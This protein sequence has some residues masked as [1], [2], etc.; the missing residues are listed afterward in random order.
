VPDDSFNTAR[1]RR[2]VLD[3]WAASPARFREDAN[4]E[5]DYALG[6]YRDRVVV[7]LAQ[8]AADAATRAGVPG[9]LALALRDGTLTAA[10][11]GAPLDADGVIALSTLRAS[12]KRGE[13]AVGR[14]GVGFAA[15][16]AV[17]DEPSISSAAGAVRWS[18]QA[19][20]DAVRQVPGLAGELAARSGHVPVLRLPFPSDQA[21]P[22]GYTTVVTLPLRDDATIELVTRLLAETGPALLLALPALAEITI[23]SVGVT[24]RLTAS[25][26]ATSA[27][28]DADAHTADTD[29]VTVT[30]TSDDEISR[31]RTAS[32]S[33]AL[34]QALLAGRPAEERA[35]PS[36]ALQWAFRTDTAGLGDSGAVLYAPTPTDEPLVLPALL[37]ASFPLSPDRR[38]VAPGPLTDYLVSRAASVYAA[39][40]PALPASPEILDLV[41]GPVA[42]GPLDGQVRRAILALLPETPFLPGAAGADQGDGGAEPAARLRP[43]D[44]VVLDVNLPELRDFLAPVLSGLIAG[45]SRHPAYT[46]LGVRRLSLAELCDMLAAL[47]RPSAWWRGLYG[48]LA[49]ADPVMR[50]ELGALPVPLADGRLVRGPRG[51]LLPG[52]GLEH[53]ERLAVLGLRAVH[54]DAAHPLLSRLGAV[55]A[56]PRSILADAATRAAVEASL[57]EEDPEP[58]A[59]AVLGLVAAAGINPDEL[60]WLASLALPG[61][62]GDWYPADEL[63]LPGGPLAEVIAQDTPFGTISEDFAQRHGAQTLETV[64]VLGSFGLVKEEDVDLGDPDLGV[65]GAT[66]W[67]EEIRE[68]LGDSDIPPLA[69]EVIAVR[70]LDLVDPD[71]WPRALEL[72]ARPPL[73]AALIEPTR[74]LLGDGRYAEAPSYTTWW[75]RRHLVIG[76]QRPAGLRAPDTDPL[77][78][79]LY[80]E[81]DPALAAALADA[82]IAR[83]LGVRT[84]LTEL[85]DEPG[86]AD[87][88]LGRLADQ[89]RPVARAQL[90]ALWAALGALSG[91]ASDATPPDRV[92]AVI[93]DQVVVA[94]AAD[95]LV[96][97]APDLWPLLAARPLVLAPYDL[98]LGLADLLD[99][100]L[101]SEE[102]PGVVE[103]PGERR[104]VPGAAAALLPDAPGEYVAHEKLLVDGVALPW[105]V[106]DGEV[107]AA[108]PDGLARGLAW[109]AGQ[110]PLRHLTAALLAAPEDAAR[111]LADADLDP[112]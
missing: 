37:I 52:S 57:D 56:T 98:A 96:L 102:V 36:W 15:T 45:P 24:R 111:L 40:L 67:A 10:N 80:D 32:A 62:D 76:G 54:P 79:G 4:A 90:R 82:A 63:L 93:G 64:G 99:L 1:L 35:R 28:A 112:S 108:S 94:D 75:L 43:R 46:V 33:G 81:A 101:A 71:R 26:D 59:E 38:H 103:S 39:V 69:P 9:R 17:S 5:E 70:D 2:S 34:G 31:W 21:P 16:V 8:N 44:A 60:P 83:A 88:L 11:T 85:L 20:A 47:D 78:D 74:V 49:A 104:P 55:E 22:D 95:S 97:D 14:F 58:V 73:R 100:P 86:G 25:R 72:L 18:R 53:P 13:D 87:D 51:L 30:I 68:H 91:T 19:A 61:D 105:R 107:H 84:S 42:H 110:W 3:A 7:E 66:D 65:D 92:R 23:E 106:H 6:G 109:A 29:T 12:S 77:L 50:T 89:A 41:P 27:E 48:A